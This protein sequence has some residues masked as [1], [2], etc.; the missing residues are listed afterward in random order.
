MAGGRVGQYNLGGYCNLRLEEL[1]KA[2]LTEADHTKRDDLIGESFRLLHEDVSHV[3]L[4]QQFLVWGV[5]K[6]L[7]VVQRA[8][9]QIMFYR[10]RKD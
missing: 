9:N 1:A 3:P 6:K 5:S 4:H 2:I 10:F 7:K 8:D